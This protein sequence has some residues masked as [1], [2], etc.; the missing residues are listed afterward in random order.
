MSKKTIGFIGLGVMGKSMARHLLEAGYPL[1]VYTRTK[2]KAEDLINQGAVWKES[3]KDLAKEVNVIITMVGFPKD[4]EEVYFSENGIL[5]NAY[6]GAICIDMTTTKPSLAEKIYEKS[7]EKGISFLDAPVSGGDVGA[8]N[9]TLSIMVGGDQ[10]TFDECFEIF[11]KMGKN[12]VYQ[13]K[14]GAG[15]HTKMCNQI[16]IAAGI[17][18]VCESLAYAVRAGLDPDKV[19]KSISSG[20]A[21]SWSLSNYAPRML[22]NQFEPGFYVKH[23]IKDMDIALEEA[24]RMELDVPGLELARSLYEKLAE[25]GEENSGIHALYK[26]WKK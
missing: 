20:A 13:G 9:G 3:I 5:A 2:E 24:R 17:I 23:F 4:V 8:K 1:T 26:L 6:P 10:E 15:Q 14:A 11:E 7:K 18:S 12:I 19:L 21:G 22:S 16:A 25:M